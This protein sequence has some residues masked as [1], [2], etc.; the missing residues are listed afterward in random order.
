MSKQMA[1]LSGSE[2]LNIIVCEDSEPETETLIA[3]TNEN[4]AYIGGDYVEGFFYAP[5]PYPSWTRSEGNWIAPISKP[6]DGFT[7]Y[8]NEVKLAWELADFSGNN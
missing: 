4:P 7:Y 1:V 2:V 3:Y 8:W 5:Q 6:T